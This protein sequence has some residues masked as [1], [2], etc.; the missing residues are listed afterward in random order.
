MPSAGTTIRARRDSR[1]NRHTGRCGRATVQIK[2]NGDAAGACQRLSQP[3]KPPGF[4]GLYLLTNTW[5]R[6]AVSAMM[7]SS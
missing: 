7:N 1:V 2:L 5:L 6:A 4:P 3:L